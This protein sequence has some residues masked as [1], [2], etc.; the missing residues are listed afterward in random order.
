[1]SRVTV[2]TGAGGGIGRVIARAFAAQGDDVVLA[3][4]RAELL[5]ETKALIESDGG[6]AVVVPTDV[7]ER[8]SVEDLAKA[9]LD[10]YGRVDVVV[11]NSGVTGPSAP[12]WEIEPSEWDETF[13][14][15]VHGVFLVCRAVI[16]AMI[17]ARS[18]SIINIGSISGK[19]PAPGRSPYAA[20]KAALI[21]LTRTLAHEVGP[22][23]IRVNSISPGFTEGP[24]IEWVIA[25]QAEARGVSES[26]I[27]AEMTGLSPLGRFTRPDDIAAAAVYLASPEASAVTGV[28]LN[29][30]AG[31]VMY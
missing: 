27:R 1:M 13:A 15:N 4:R 21:G 17:E 18:G 7:T 24:R 29:V 30:N 28:D 31:V 23:G 14:V 6:R 10:R 20:A 2:V 22:Y 19:R 26:E 12:L 3:A 16:P 25:R 9:A 8:A 5:E 11:N